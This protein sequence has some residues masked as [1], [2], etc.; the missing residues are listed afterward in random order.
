MLLISAFQSTHASKRA[1]CCCTGQPRLIIQHSNLRKINCHHCTSLDHPHT[2]FDKVVQHRT[3]STDSLTPPP[4]STSPFRPVTTSVDS[5]TKPPSPAQ[6]AQDARITRRGS[7]ATTAPVMHEDTAFNAS[8]GPSIPSAKRPRPAS[9][10]HSP[11]KRVRARSAT[12]IPAENESITTSVDVERAVEV[13]QTVSA[14]YGTT[15]AGPSSYARMEYIKAEDEAGQTSETGSVLFSEQ[16]DTQQSQV[17]GSTAVKGHLGDY[18]PQP[19]PTM[20]P[21]TEE[22]GDSRD[23]SLRT[24]D[25]FEAEEEEDA[26][27]DDG[28][29]ELDP[30][31]GN[32][33]LEESH[34]NQDDDDN[35][36]E[37]AA[38]TPKWLTDQHT[39]IAERR[40]AMTR[41]IEGREGIEVIQERA[42][43]AGLEGQEAEDEEE[44]DD[45]PFEHSYHSGDT[46][47]YEMDH[48]PV[49]ERTAIKRD[50]RHFTE[51]LASLRDATTGEIAYKVVDRLG[52]G[53]WKDKKYLSAHS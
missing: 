48:R 12:P 45:G 31:E 43:Y 18:I 44:S 19:D 38:A 37:D 49:L 39:L 1:V 9:P 16:V 13:D 8:A 22:T 21:P 11:N 52:E 10:R 36:D 4:T 15:L 42:Q 46:E 3:M 47:D 20:V 34:D 27:V 30:E 2:S 40:D 5:M 25:V 32:E 41:I 53:R 14:G 29:Q 35:D 17:S 28:E 6:R 50:I 24:G 33:M 26:G 7:N 23:G 51:S